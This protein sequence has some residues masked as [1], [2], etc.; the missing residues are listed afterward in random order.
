M[1]L[2]TDSLRVYSR[3][4]SAQ[5]T[6]DG[7][8]GASASFGGPSLMVGGG[9]GGGLPALSFGRK[10]R[11]IETDDFDHA[12]NSTNVNENSFPTPSGITEQQAI[13]VY[14]CTICTCRRMVVR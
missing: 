10:R 6:V 4:A 5:S 1:A 14:V 7:N 3:A 2:T 12:E 11:S 13:G 9:V 8:T